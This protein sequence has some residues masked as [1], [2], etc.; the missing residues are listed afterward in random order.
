MINLLWRMPPPFHTLLHKL[1]GWVIMAYL[2]ESYPGPTASY[3]KYVRRL[4]WKRLRNG[5]YS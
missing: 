2:D 5:I 1:T 3:R 4:E